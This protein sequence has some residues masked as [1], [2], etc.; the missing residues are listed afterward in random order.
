MR[1]GEWFVTKWVFVNRGCDEFE[2]SR[3]FERI[4]R[5]ACCYL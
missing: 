1:I 3:I 2:S 4:V 5:G